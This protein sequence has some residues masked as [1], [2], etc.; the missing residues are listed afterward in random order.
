MS[1]TTTIP[2]SFDLALLRCAAGTD[3]GMR[4]DENQDSFGVIRREY[5]HA[6]F[7]ADGMGGA[8]GG[9]TASR[10]A[11]SLL[12]EALHEPQLRIS[13]PLLTSIVESINRRIFE[14]GSTEP[15]C[16]GMG[17]TLVG[18]VFTTDALFGVNVGDSRA[19]R[20]RGDSITQISEDHTLVRELVQSGAISPEDAQHHPVSHMLTR[21]LGPLGEVQVECR[22]TPEPPQT[23][24][25]YV[26]CSDGLYN[27]VPQ[28][29]ILAVVKQNPLDDANQILIN[30]ANQRGGSDNITAVVIAV[31]EKPVRGRKTTIPPASIESDI[32][33]ETVT[34]ITPA[35]TIEEPPVIPPP[36]KEPTDI[37]AQRKALRQRQRA[38]LR[39]PRPIPTAFLLGVT[40]I[41]GLVLGNFARK[42]SLEGTPHLG[43]LLGFREQV[44]DETAREATASHEP[45]PL[46]VLAKQ[47]GSDR[48]ES[49][50]ILANSPNDARRQ[51][52]Q[53][54]QS[55]RKLKAQI[56]TLNQPSGQLKAEALDKSRQELS[57][58]EK[59]YQATESNLDVASRLVTLWLGRQ[60]AFDGQ[61]ISMDS[62]TEMARVGTYSPIV[63]GKV[64]LFTSLSYQYRQ[65]ADDLEL[66]PEDTALEVELAE[67]DAR[68]EALKKELATDLLQAIKQNLA[69]S[70][71]DYETTKLQRDA[72][73]LDLQAA[74]REVEIQKAIAEGDVSKRD[75]LLRSLEERLAQ[76]QRTLDAIR[77]ASAAR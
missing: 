47:M 46:A 6:Y 33:K 2:G 71:K 35:D 32:D 77:G 15:A 63:K 55:I 17:T 59:S 72:L 65:K 50:S 57:K 68:R 53:L 10:M 51:P 69:K 38:A 48:N 34:L 40:L 43:E 14:K 1:T 41:L 62:L 66:H 20:I 19:Y 74:K 52:A 3:V 9:A 26:L 76:E 28:E 4:R 42:F 23:G 39:G 75:S 25:I 64:D 67:L 12:T 37:N 21:S 29:D 73:W 56:Q 54:E 27:Y 44:D 16:A 49:V 18:L 36:I 61:E 5:F 30:L 8:Q 58:L 22:T 70:F 60:V 13:P 7:V 11:I 24:D 31:G 45:N